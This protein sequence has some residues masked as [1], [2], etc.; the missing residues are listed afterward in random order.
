MVLLGDA[1]NPKEGLAFISYMLRPQAIAE[2]TNYLGYPP[3]P[4][5]DT[6]FPLEPLPLK[7]ERIRTRL[8]NKVKTGS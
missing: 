2:S 1:P 8:W 6:L 5:P 3:K 7:Y 4:V